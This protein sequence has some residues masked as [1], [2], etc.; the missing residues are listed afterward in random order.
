[1]EGMAYG[2]GKAGGAFN[3]ITFFQQ[4][5]TILRILS[6]STASYSK[7][8]LACPNVRLHTSSDSVCGVC[9][10]KASSASLSHTASFFSIVI[11]GSIANEGYVNRPDE[12]QEFCIFNRNQNACNYGLF[13][14]TLAFLCCLVF[15][16]LDV[17][18]PQIS[19]VKDRKKAVLADVGVSAFWSFMWFVG[20]CFLTN[21]WQVAKQEDNPLREGGDAARAAITFAFFSIFTW[22][23][24]PSSPSSLLFTSTSPPNLHTSTSLSTYPIPTLTSST[25]PPH[26]LHPTSIPLPFISPPTYTPLPPHLP[27]ISLHLTPQPTPLYLPTSLPFPFISPPTYTPLPPH[28]PRISLHL[29]PNL[30]PS[31]SPPPSL[32]TSSHPPTPTMPSHT[33][34]FT[35]LLPPS[36]R[37]PSPS[38]AIR[39]TSWGQ[40]LLSS[41]RT[42]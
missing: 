7:M 18:F 24:P 37:R 23:P 33:T 15:L 13:M 27:H 26:L 5:H 10:E 16:A 31:T 20:F 17:Y 11:F 12:A 8:K 41:P 9:A 6:W 19:S 36:P 21:Q 1:M 25:I 29:T 28:L 38:S 22:P 40:T 32:F 3:P 34:L 39:G 42:T 30:H 2:A 14:G 4:P 35:H